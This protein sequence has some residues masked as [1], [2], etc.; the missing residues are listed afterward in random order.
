[1]TAPTSTTVAPT[2]GKGTT[3]S[4]AGG[5]ATAKAYPKG[6]PKVSNNNLGRHPRKAKKTTLPSSVTIVLQPDGAPSDNRE[7]GTSQKSPAKRNPRGATK[8][9]VK[10]KKE[11]K[12]KLLQ[13]QKEEDDSLLD[14]YIARLDGEGQFVAD[15][16][17][18]KKQKKKEKKVQK[19]RGGGA[20]ASDISEDDEGSV[21]SVTAGD[22]EVSIPSTDDESGLDEPAAK[23]VKAGTPD[24]PMSYLVVLNNNE[25]FTIIRGLT[26]AEEEFRPSNPMK[27]KLIALADMTQSGEDAPRLVVLE[28]DYPWGPVEVPRVYVNNVTDHYENYHD[29]PDAAKMR[30]FDENDT[31]DKPSWNLQRRIWVPPHWVDRFSFCPFSAA[32]PLLEEMWEEQNIA[33]W[34]GCLS[35]FGWVATACCANTGA[36]TIVLAI[37]ATTIRKSPRATAAALRIWNKSQGGGATSATTKKRQEKPSKR[38]STAPAASVTLKAGKRQ[39]KNPTKRQRAA[40]VTPQKRQKPRKS[41]SS[42]ATSDPSSGD[43]SSSDSSSSSRSESD[44][45]DSD[46]SSATSDS[47]A[48]EEE[49]ETEEARCYHPS[50]DLKDGSLDHDDATREPKDLEARSQGTR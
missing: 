50:E 28:E 25:H 26:V 30:G 5:T 32:M 3:R 6:L 44:S 17:V 23:K 18:T 14:S 24:E 40:P 47:D 16:A 34:S 2:Q 7:G 4:G 38:R 21:E 19:K 1:M 20:S 12:K 22:L 48:Q 13:A 10:E 8:Q 41:T 45:E 11:K 31:D 27:G 37:R 36:D 29:M 46:D 49:E 33:N 9:A 42:A 15:C 35:F 39:K 43:S